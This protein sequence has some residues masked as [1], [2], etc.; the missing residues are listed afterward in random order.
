LDEMVV[1]DTGST[2]RTKAIAAELGARV[3]DFPWVDSFAAARNE[4]LRHATGGWVFWL[5]ADDRLDE[6]N[7]AKLQTLLRSLRDDNAAYVMKCHCLPDQETGTETVVDHVR[8]FRNLPGLH[9]R[10][11]VHEQILPEL[12]RRGTEVRWSDVVI[13]H[14]GYQDR[15]ARGRKLQRDLR[16]LGLEND[17]HPD[18]PFTL[19]NLGCVHNEQGKLDEAL[20]YLRRSLA[21][22]APGDSIVR[23]LYALIC[24]CSNRLDRPAEALE[25]CRQGLVVAPDDTEL[26]FQEGMICRRLGNVAGAIAS[27]ERLLALPPGQYYASVHAGIRGYVTRHNLA[28]VYREQGDQQRAETQWRQALEERPGFEPAQRGLAELL[29]ESSRWVELQELIEVTYTSGNDIT[30]AALRARMF[31]K[32]R[33]FGKARRL[34]EETITKHPDALEARVL[35]THA[36]L[37]E[38]QD[39][40]GAERALRAVLAIAPDHEETRRNLEVLLRQRGWA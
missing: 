19:F 11:R 22:S 35:L 29:M 30:A 38:G 28:L 13:Q 20:A 34:L 9:W 26:L 3:F 8:L 5:D 14:T 23:K 37:Q 24:Q 40:D 31:L 7:R 27:W 16:L 17:E 12:R 6:G 25:V 1:V 4:S 33:E 36:L 39:W 32:R 10:Y 18:D 2:D 15:S 21:L